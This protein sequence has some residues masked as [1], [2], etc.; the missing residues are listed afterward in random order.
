VKHSFWWA[1]LV[2]LVVFGGLGAFPVSRLPGRVRA[3]PSFPQNAAPEQRV[4]AILE[5]NAQ[6]ATAIG[7]AKSPPDL[8]RADPENHFKITT[9]AFRMWNGNECLSEFWREERGFAGGAGCCCCR[10]IANTKHVC[11]GSAAERPLDCGGSNV[12]DGH[13]E[14]R[15]GEMLTPKGSCKNQQ[16]FR[17]GKLQDLLDIRPAYNYEQICAYTPPRRAS[18]GMGCGCV[19]CWTVYWPGMG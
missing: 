17:G 7:G 2:A 10:Q 6:R 11:G 15:K 5:W 8:Q 19:Q 14:T 13:E 4:E 1:S 16:T 3:T 18:A 9:I 12:S